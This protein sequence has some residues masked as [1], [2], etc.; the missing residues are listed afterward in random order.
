M[1]Q[2]NIKHL[3]N[4]GIHI[5][6]A[7][8]DAMAIATPNKNKNALNQA[9]IEKFVREHYISTLDFIP[10]D[11]KI[12]ACRN[13][14]NIALSHHTSSHPIIHFLTIP[15]SPSKFMLNTKKQ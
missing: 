11:F 13:A 10:R 7:L 12:N 9:A 8:P 4:I 2:R 14:Q 3:Y 15:I 6:H 5:W 1:H